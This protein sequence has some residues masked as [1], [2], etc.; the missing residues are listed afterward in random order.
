MRKQI[1][2][3]TASK[4]LAMYIVIIHK[5]EFTTAVNVHACLWY[6]YENLMIVPVIKYIAR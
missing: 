3:T 1:S 4:Q 2:A 5:P 6:S